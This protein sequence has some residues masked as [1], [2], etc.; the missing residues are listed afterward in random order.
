MNNLSNSNNMTSS[1]SFSNKYNNSNKLNINGID[2]VRS[3]RE[4][5]QI[6][7]THIENNFTNENKNKYY[8]INNRYEKSRIYL[9]WKIV[10]V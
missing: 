2:Y 8:S 5:N 1:L 10:Q 4:N 3:N 6:K 7:L 9:S